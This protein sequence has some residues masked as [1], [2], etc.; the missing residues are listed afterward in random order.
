VDD[1]QSQDDI[2]KHPK[3]KRPFLAIPETGYLIVIRKNFGCVIV[4]VM[5][6]KIVIVDD[7]EKCNTYPNDGD[8]MNIK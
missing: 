4:C 6:L 1:D 2:P 8:R 5:I 7:Q 3:Q